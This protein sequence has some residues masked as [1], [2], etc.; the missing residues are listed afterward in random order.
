MDV[1]IKNKEKILFFK[2]YVFFTNN[3]T[4]LNTKWIILHLWNMYNILKWTF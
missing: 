2:N 1:K 4:I 3:L